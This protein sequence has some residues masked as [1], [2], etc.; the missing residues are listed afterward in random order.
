LAV[1]AIAALVY[2]WWRG[3]ITPLVVVLL[4]E[5]VLMYRLRKRMDGVLHGAE[6]AL[7]DLNLLSGVLARIE[8]QRGHSP[9]LLALKSKLGP[10]ARPASQAIARLRT[11][12][13]LIDSRDNMFVRVFDVPLLYSVQVAILAERWR[14]AHG[15]QVRGWLEAVGEIEALLSLAAYSF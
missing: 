6:H 9:R 11:I 10:E 12:G 8:R 2:S 13:D 7:R 5:G 14:S 4:A 1:L 3:P 15:A